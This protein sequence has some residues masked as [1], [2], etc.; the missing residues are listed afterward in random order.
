MLMQSS[1]GYTSR[2]SF[3]HREALRRRGLTDVTI[4]AAGLWS[5]SA[6]QVAELLGFDPHSAGLVIPYQHPRTEK[7]ALNRVRPDYPPII[8]QK[9]AKYLSPKGASNRLYFLRT[10]LNLYKIPASLLFS[11]KVILKPCGD[12]NLDC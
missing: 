3:E 11:L 1:N 9:P 6:E 4:E 2:L 12:I 7:V 10:L 5:A 8:G